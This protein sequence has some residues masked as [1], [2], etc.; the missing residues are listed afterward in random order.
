[1]GLLH[2][3]I[4][5]VAELPHASVC[6]LA[7]VAHRPPEAIDHE[8][9]LVKWIGSADD[10]PRSARDTP[11]FALDNL[12][13]VA[14]GVGTVQRNRTRN[15]VCQ[16]GRRWILIVAI[17]RVNQSPEAEILCRLKG[18]AVGKHDL[19]EFRIVP[20]LVQLQWRHGGQKLNGRV[21]FVEVDGRVKV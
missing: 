16:R 9:L 7:L 3:L 21:R 15:A 10:P 17:F 20:D 12:D 5:R 8:R 18:L 14:V 6:E 13:P 1:M 19:W 4:P 11:G 2:L